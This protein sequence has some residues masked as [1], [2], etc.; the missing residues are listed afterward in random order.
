MKSKIQVGVSFAIS[1]PNVFVQIEL[2]LS[3]IFV[4]LLTKR[5]VRNVLIR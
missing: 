2:K 5:L 4:I 1:I 3:I